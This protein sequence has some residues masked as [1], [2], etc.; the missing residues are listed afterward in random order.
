V[1]LVHHHVG[2]INFNYPY[3]RD[4]MFERIGNGS[5]WNAITR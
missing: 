2:S 3:R 1:T 4:R 5:V